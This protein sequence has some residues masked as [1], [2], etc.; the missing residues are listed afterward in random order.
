MNTA[1]GTTLGQIG[2][3]PSKLNIDDQICVHNFIICTKLKQP[4]IFRLNFNQRYWTGID[5]D[6]SGTLFL[7]HEGKKIATF[8]K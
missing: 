1:S 8:M 3:Y 6:M 5:W 4:L 2:I 7:R